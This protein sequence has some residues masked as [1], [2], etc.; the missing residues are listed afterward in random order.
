MVLREDDGLKGYMISV[1]EKND[2]LSRDEFISFV[3]AVLKKKSLEENRPLYFE[4]RVSEGYEK[5]KFSNRFDAFAPEGF[6]EYRNPVIFEFIDSRVR[7]MEQVTKRIKGLADDCRKSYGATVIFILNFKSP[8]KDSNLVV[9]DLAVINNWVEEYPTEYSH[10]CSLSIGRRETARDKE[11]A[12]LFEKLYSEDLYLKNNELHT[13]AIRTCI[14][15]Q[16]GFAIVLGAGVSKEQGA[17]TWDEL[18]KDFQ[19]EIEERRLLDDSEAVFEEVGGSSL[20]TARLCK[21]IWASEKTFA[22]QIHKSLYD[23]AQ[24]LNLNTE[25]GEIAQLAQRCQGDRNFRILSYNYDDFLEQYLD[26]LNV[27]CCSMFTTKI[28][29]SNGRDSADFY[30]MNGQPNQSLRLYHVH[31]FLPKV[32]TRDQLDTL[33]MRSICLTEADYNMLYNQPYSWPIASQLSFFR[34]NTCLFIGC[35]LSD[36]NIRRLL[37]I[38]AYNLPKHYAIFSMTYESTD[39]HGSTTTKQLT[40]KDRLQIEN[41]FYRIG[42]NI[43]WVKDYREIPVWL[44]NLNQSIV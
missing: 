19:K 34:E 36:P 29:Y 33:H 12:Q 25:L 17:K 28:R 32:A 42:I 41:H 9:W 39:A 3:K 20:T 26:F 43:L 31:G 1:S 8:F 37:E 11:K 2:K 24:D 18:L 13:N 27:R 14:K 6:S 23:A 35:S 44:H 4:Y 21:D 16:N 10:A 7:K 5:E 22:W 40:S 15:E 30:G 38:T